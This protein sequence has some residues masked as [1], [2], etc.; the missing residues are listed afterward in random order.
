[1]TLQELYMYIMNKYEHSWLTVMSAGVG[2]SIIKTYCADGDRIYFVT[3]T[4][5]LRYPGYYSNKMTHIIQS[6]YPINAIVYQS[7][8]IGAVSSI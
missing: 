3:S 5:N 8:T 7:G 6:S 4:T 1:M 2:Y